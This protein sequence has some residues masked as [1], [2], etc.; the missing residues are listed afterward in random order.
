MPQAV[1]PTPDGIQEFASLILGRSLTHA[2]T[3][4]ERGRERGF[5]LET[6]IRGWLGTAACFLGKLWQVDQCR[7][8]EATVGFSHL[9][10]MLCDFCPKFECHVCPCDERKRAFLL[11]TPGVQHTFGSF[12]AE[13]FFRREGWDVARGQIDA[14][15]D[16]AHLVGK[17]CFAVIGF[18]LSC[19][20][21]SGRLAS[22]IRIVQRHSCSGDIGVKASGSFFAQKPH[23]AERAGADGFAAEARAAVM[24]TC[25]VLN[26]K[27]APS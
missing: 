10:P 2:H 21:F 26:R 13:A 19:E 27:F 4:V 23:R 20:R 8:A 25:S 22:L 16:I 5:S 12:V 1:V 14:G 17:Q 7:F 18:S 24:N 11:V 15:D 9:R 3:F 6:V